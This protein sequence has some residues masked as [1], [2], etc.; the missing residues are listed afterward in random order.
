MSEKMVVWDEMSEAEKFKALFL[1]RVHRRGRDELLEHLETEGF[2]V[3][4]A[5]TRYHGSYAGGLVEH[6]NNVFRR[7]AYLASHEAMK[8]KKATYTIETLVIVSLL[9]DVCK[10]KQYIRSTSG[11]YIYNPDDLAMG[12]GEKSV[13]MIQKHMQL[14]D[15]EA[16]AIRWH[17]GAYDA[18]A[19]SSFRQLDTAM[20]QSKLVAM[21]HLADMMA[22]HL[23]DK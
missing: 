6:S 19:Q 14:T 4:P 15:E 21:L 2:F 18:A 12:H 10:S 3:A 20:K 7:L 5:S 8:A 9:H 1:C 16:L 13:Y 17:M 22:T 11:D 23:D